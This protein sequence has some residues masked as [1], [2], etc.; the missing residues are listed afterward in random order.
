[1]AC[2]PRPKALVEHSSA[3]RVRLL[4][5]VI[6]RTHTKMVDSG[7]GL[8]VYSPKEQGLV[9]FSKFGFP[10]KGKMYRTLTHT[11]EQI[12]V[13]CRLD[14]GAALGWVK[15]LNP[16]PLNPRPLSPKPLNT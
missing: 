2:L 7:L 16:K 11:F 8:S 5:V 3:P 4:N 15:T 9:W 10:A 12:A 6:E 1:M 14:E 13:S